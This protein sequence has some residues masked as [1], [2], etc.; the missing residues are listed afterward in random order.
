MAQYDDHVKDNK[1]SLVLA[2]SWNDSPYT[3][4]LKT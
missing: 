3:E 2:F 1:M 4:R